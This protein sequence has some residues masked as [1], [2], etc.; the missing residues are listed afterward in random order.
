MAGHEIAAVGVKEDEEAGRVSEGD[1]LGLLRVE[2][3]TEGLE[4]PN[5]PP[6]CRQAV[7]PS[8]QGLMKLYGI[9]KLNRAQDGPGYPMSRSET[10]SDIFAPPNLPVDNPRH[11]ATG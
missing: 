2:I 3:Y 5:L 1:Q 11:V 10:I 4:I 7:D 9:S 6:G 8:S